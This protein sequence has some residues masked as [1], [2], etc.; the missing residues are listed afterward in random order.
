MRIVISRHGESSYNLE[1][2]IGGN[3]SLSELGHEYGKRLGDFFH[4]T[5][6]HCTSYASTK[7]RV[8]ETIGYC[9]DNYTQYS[10]LDEINAGICEDL[11]YNDVIEKYPEE[12]LARKKDKLNYRYPKGESYI[13]IVSR[14][15]P[16]IDKILSDGDTNVFIVC[17]RAITRSLLYSFGVIELSE[18]STYN[19]P[20]HHV[21][22]LSG[23]RG[24]MDLV[25]KKL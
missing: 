8:L 16:I 25:V 10:E 6:P 19:V 13:D 4:S 17:H 24:K 1:Q 15:L 14:T 21:L 20:L 22:I 7:K 5:I 12:F 23:D 3:P 18:L 2:R 9:T 11:T